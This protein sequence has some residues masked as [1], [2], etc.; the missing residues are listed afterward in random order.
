MMNRALVP[1]S[2]VT[3]L[4][5]WLRRYNPRIIFDFDDDIY[6]GDNQ[7]SKISKIISLTAWVTPGNTY[8]AEFARQYNG[9]V[10]IIPTVVD[11]DYYKPG[12]LREP[13]IV[14]VG[15]TGS[16]DTLRFHLPLVRP[17]IIKLSGQE[18]FEF[19][20]IANRPPEGA[21]PGVKMRFIP[22]NSQTEVRDHQLIDIGLM[23]LNDSPHE[24]GK[25]GAKILLYGAFNSPA[26]ASP[27][28]VNS[29]II[30]PGET[31]F[32]ANTEEEWENGLRQLIRDPLLRKNMGVA[33]R[34]RVE[35]H[36]SVRAMLPRLMQ[37]FEQTM[38]LYPKTI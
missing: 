3:F 32:L 13:G 31:G 37:I 4:E 25:C 12:K 33:A 29:E 35:E 27:V 6:S 10:I 17:L 30:L 1:E 26:I 24:R 7:Q 2:W 16:E 15:W 23:P 8:L 11:T 20:V 22:W 18:Q 36:Y 38:A 21:W 19:I 28:G 34:K 14:R 9:H 5:P